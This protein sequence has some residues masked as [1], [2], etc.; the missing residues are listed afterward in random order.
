MSIFHLLSGLLLWALTHASAAA[1][2][3]TDGADDDDAAL[4]DT[5]RFV[6]DLPSVLT[7]S[8][9][10][11]AK[12]RCNVRGKPRPVGCVNMDF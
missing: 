1:Y 5:L 8:N 7:F 9:T 11:G 6:S 4:E 10:T 3:I 12:L 2:G